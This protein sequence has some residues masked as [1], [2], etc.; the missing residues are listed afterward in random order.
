MNLEDEI[1]PYR[2]TLIGHGALLIFCGGV[3]GFGFL[4]FLMGHISLWPIPGAINFQMPGNYIAWRMAHLE[5]IL[6]GSI[7]WLLAA[8]LPLLPFSAKGLRRI[9]YGMITVAW[10]FVLA[11]TIKP[12]FRNSRGLE[13]SHLLSNNV[14]FGLFYVGV[15]L[16]MGIMAIIAV[17]SLRG[18]RSL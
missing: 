18:A 10:T 13:A 2:R 17:K 1:K 12:L 15:V 3:I 8:I 14:V 7:L 5:A 9:T 11:S 6:N 4:F 16:V